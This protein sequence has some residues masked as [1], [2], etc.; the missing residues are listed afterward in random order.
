MKKAKTSLKMG[1]LVTLV[2][3]W[4]VPTATIVTLMSALLGE[5]Y[6]QSMQQEITAEAE[7]AVER[8][9]LRLQS[10]VE[11]SKQVSYD[12]VV[13][14]AYREY[15]QDGHGIT[16]YRA[17]NDYLNQRLAWDKKYQAIFINFWTDAVAQ[18]SVLGGGATGRGAVLAFQERSGEILAAMADTDTEIRFFLLDGELYMARNLLDS[19]FQAYATVVM[20]FDP[21][22]MFEPLETLDTAGGVEVTVGG[23]AFRLGPECELLELEEAGD[24][25]RRLEYTA[26]VDGVDFFVAVRTEDAS[27]WEIHPW[28][29]WTVALALALALPFLIVA[30][31][32]FTRHVSEPMKIIAEAN[33]RVTSGERGYQ[34]TRRPPNAD[35]ERLYANFN[36]MSR[37]LKSQFERSALEQQ[38]T[39]QAR[40][41]ALQHQISPHF[42]NNTLEIINWEARLEGN[43]R[44]SAMIEALSTMLDAAL[45]RNNQSKILLRDE[46]GYV[47]AYLYI[48]QER[49]GEG[50]HAYK[51]IDGDI[52]DQMIPRMILQP[53]VENAVEHDITARRGG[54]LWVRAFRRED[55]LV[56]EVEHDG[57][58]TEE[59]RRS[60]DEL[61]AE[62]APEGSQVGLRNVWQ[63]LRLIYGP[64]A[65]LRVE[66]TDAGTIMARISLP[67][68]PRTKPDEKGETL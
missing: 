34:I 31:V 60:I 6:R 45:D 2:I 19:S 16:L 8:V 22:Y 40:I 54:N 30:I 35:F 55:R 3:C 61:L 43:D 44:V 39:Q 56:L 41:K 14:Y 21:Q 64:E 51:E 57:T 53:I 17:V 5:S 4:L 67:M 23:Y 32:L 38:A 33:G 29:G 36:E 11:D 52:L 1:L 48:I 10:A 65:G 59:D 58:M 49:L 46:L 66:G 20:M 62:P 12:G 18:P 42:L 24:T 68:P 27:V 25:F 13:R 37:E 47:D 15:L 50:F 26:P 63:R 28:L 7:S 9:Q